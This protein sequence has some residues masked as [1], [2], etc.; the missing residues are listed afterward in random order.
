MTSN[1]TARK[2]NPPSRRPRVAGRGDGAL[3]EAVRRM[4]GQVG[5]PVRTWLAAM[6]GDE[7][8]PASSGR[9][10]RKA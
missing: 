6:A 2:A 1:E 5:E 10:R 4:A 7:A 8:A 9:E 3:A